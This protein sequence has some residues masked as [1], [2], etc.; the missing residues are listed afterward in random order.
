M[1]YDSVTIKNGA[2][3]AFKG[4]CTV[5]FIVFDKTVNICFGDKNLHVSV[6]YKD[7]IVAEDIVFL[8]A[9]DEIPDND[10][11][12]DDALRIALKKAGFTN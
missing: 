6:F 12:L 9:S 5:Y 8:G 11:P 3:I 7:I 4:N 1:F 2:V 10:V